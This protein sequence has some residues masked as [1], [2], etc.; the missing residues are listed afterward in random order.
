METASMSMSRPCKRLPLRPPSSE[1]N[2]Y[3]VRGAETNHL[4]PFDF[5]RKMPSPRKD[6]TQMR[7]GLL[8]NSQRLFSLL[9]AV[10]ELVGVLKEPL[11]RRGLAEPGAV[12]R[13]LKVERGEE[14][15]EH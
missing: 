6:G 13:V 3:T 10:E 15:H 2:L 7:F 11:V 5:Y 1:D 12:A 14:V 9:E 8:R 4:G